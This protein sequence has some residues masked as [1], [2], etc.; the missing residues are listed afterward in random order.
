MSMKKTIIWVVVAIL[1][2]AIGIINYQK[3]G[4]SG[5]VSEKPVIKIGIIGPLTGGA[6]VYGT[7]LVKGVELGGNRSIEIID[8]RVTTG[9]AYHGASH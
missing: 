2:V 5:V 8:P 4:G 3:K 1:V 7:N 9:L 6:S